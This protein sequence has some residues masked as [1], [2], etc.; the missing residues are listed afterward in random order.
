M[1]PELDSLICDDLKCS[2]AFILRT[3][4]LGITSILVL[5]EV[6]FNT[7]NHGDPSICDLL[8]L[9][10]KSEEDELDFDKGSHTFTDELFSLF[11]FGIH[12]K[13]PWNSLKTGETFNLKDHWKPFHAK[14]FCFKLKKHANSLA[15]TF[16]QGLDKFMAECLFY[17]ACLKPWFEQHQSSTLLASPIHRMTVVES[18]AQE[19]DLHSFDS[20]FAL[21]HSSKFHSNGSKPPVASKV[22]GAADSS[23]SSCSDSDADASVIS[24]LRHDSSSHAKEPKVTV[25]DS[26]EPKH[27]F[28]GNACKKEPDMPSG[29]SVATPAPAPSSQKL[30]GVKKEPQKL[31]KGSN[32]T[33]IHKKDQDKKKLAIRGHQLSSAQVKGDVKP[34]HSAIPSAS[35]KTQIMPSF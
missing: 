7:D 23:S 35:R 5:L 25:K 29:P 24:Q 10:C 26:V 22:S 21:S 13:D 1:D 9:F 15:S 33:K 32:L 14:S 34:V 20:K 30:R 17:E 18:M 4:A 8:Q 31:K 28:F 12:V 2:E 6:I 27:V 3:E 19:Q 16:E 11:C